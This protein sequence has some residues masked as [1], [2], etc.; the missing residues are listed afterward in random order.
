MTSYLGY[1]YILLSIPYQQLNLKTLE[2]TTG[3]FFKKVQ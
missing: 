2:K 3:A 1:I